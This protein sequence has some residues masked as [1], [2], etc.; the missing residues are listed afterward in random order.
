MAFGLKYE[1]LDKYLQSYGSYIV[2]QAKGILKKRNDTGKLI[3]SL[4]YKITRDDRTFKIQFLNSKYGKFVNKGVS[5]T[6]TT[7]TYV[8]K[9]GKR[10]RSPFKYRA[11]S[12]LIALENATGIFRKYA[13]RKGLKGRD[14]GYTKKDGTKVKGTGRFITDKQLGFMIASSVKKKGI[15]AASFYTK[16]LSW[17]FSTFIKDLEKNLASDIKTVIQ[18]I[19]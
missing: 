13:K 8:T 14:R 3:K 19:K 18:K 16:P 10:K 2:R 7:R 15:K 12:N 11:T 9:E 4:N 17:S 6:E 1:N 5:G